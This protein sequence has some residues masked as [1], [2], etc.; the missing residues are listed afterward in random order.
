M[1]K[2]A[3]TER[4][5]HLTLLHSNDLH[6][7]FL[8]KELDSNL[9][10]GV[11]MLSGYLNQV[12]REEPNTLYM[13]AGDMFR[14]SLIDTEFQGISTIDIMNAL[15]PDVVSLG[16]HEMDYGIAHL[17]FLEKCCKFPIV[18]AN[19]YIKTNGLRLFR[20][21]K[22]LKVD[23][24]K[25]LVIGILTEE[26]MGRA[27]KDTLL[28]TF[29][30]VKDAAREVSVICNSCKNTD[31]DFTILL[32]HIGF[33]NDLALAKELDPALGIDIII[34]GH[35]HTLPE[36]P[37]KVGDI[38]V[39]QAGVGT[40][41]IGRFDIEVDTERNAIE[42]YTWQT[43]PIDASH[44]QKNQAMEDLILNYKKITD[45]KYGAILTVL[46]EAATH[47]N[48]YQETTAGNLFADILCENYNLDLALVGSGSLR[49]P[50][51]GPIVTVGGLL[52]MYAYDEKML[53]ITL[54]GAELKTAMAC[55]L[56]KALTPEGHSEYYQLSSGFRFQ[57]SRSRHELV[58]AACNGVPI[59]DTQ[60]F[61]VGIEGYHADN[62]L[63]FMNIDP[64]VVRA[65]A[66]W[67]T[68]TSNVRVAV[69]EYLRGHQNLIPRLEGRT[70]IVE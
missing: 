52:D 10:G 50:S 39:V 7:D 12:R 9:V 48:R 13:V 54:T 31:I 51:L 64:E 69:E 23:G 5:R 20:S 4:Y 41:Q 11:A 67:I 40:D 49:V 46:N 58:V 62:M 6:G 24:M 38:L 35:S 60:L 15:G 21:H 53:R 34:G 63:A 37:A 30:N 59:S 32:T 17:L 65:R 27:Q 47:P 22:I 45:E 42:S 56:E 14:G 2:P 68:L 33:E 8:A 18:N 26:I 28:G 36:A 3:S 29:V 57:Y 44:C 25:I 55:A 1:N 16:N 66:P 43:I 19:V 61:T 70:G